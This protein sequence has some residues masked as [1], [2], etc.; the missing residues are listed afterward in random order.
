MRDLLEAH[1]SGLIYDA[2]KKAFPTKRWHHFVLSYSAQKHLDDCGLGYRDELFPGRKELVN[3]FLPYFAK[4]F[5]LRALLECLHL[6]EEMITT[7]TQQIFDSGLVYALLCGL[8][9]DPPYDDDY[10]PEER[11]DVGLLSP[12][13]GLLT[14]LLLNCGNKE[15]KMIVNHGLVGRLKT[16]LT[17]LSFGEDDAINIFDALKSIVKTSP[18][19]RDKVLQS[20]IVTRFSKPLPLE[21]E[22][23]GKSCVDMLKAMLCNK[24]MPAVEYK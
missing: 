14:K 21:S 15:V 17:Y 8:E 5:D 24:E 9:F 1:Q 20:D 16:M 18:L 19:L 23:V 7:H 3:E 2:F 22:D 12:F 6:V 4:R 13:L 10:T 11:P